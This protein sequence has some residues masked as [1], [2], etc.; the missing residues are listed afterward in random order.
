VLPPRTTKKLP[1]RTFQNVRCGSV[2]EPVWNRSYGMA[3][4]MARVR[5]SH[6]GQQRRNHD[7]LR[8]RVV[9]TEPAPTVEALPTVTEES[10][11]ASTDDPADTVSEPARISANDPHVTTQPTTPLRRST[12]RRK[13]PDRYLP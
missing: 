9:R 13:P 2:C 7:Q 3:D 10:T 4:R 1:Q 8:N 11:A 5:D 6:E 12:R